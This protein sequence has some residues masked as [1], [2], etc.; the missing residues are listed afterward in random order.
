[1][2]NAL[3]FTTFVVTVLLAFVLGAVVGIAY[4]PPGD[5]LA[6]RDAINLGEQRLGLAV[7]MAG[8]H[9]SAELDGL[10]AQGNRIYPDYV[11]S[12]R[13]CRATR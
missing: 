5:L 1:M 7:K 8:T 9:D 11:E 6:C 4:R 10:L 2:T 12:T 13:L 3:K